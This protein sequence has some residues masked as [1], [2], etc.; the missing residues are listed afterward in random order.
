[1][2]EILYPTKKGRY[3]I[4]EEDSKYNREKKQEVNYFYDRDYLYYERFKLTFED[5]I[6]AV[7]QGETLQIKFGKKWRNI[8]SLDINNYTPVIRL[9]IYNYKDYRIKPHGFFGSFKKWIKNKTLVW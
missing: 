4:K 3:L 8:P 9:S 7:E 5:I 6:Q 1:M 2:N